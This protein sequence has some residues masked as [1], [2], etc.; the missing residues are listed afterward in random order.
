MTTEIGPLHVRR[1]IWIDAKPERVWEEFEDL[2]HMRA[3]FGT[4]HSLTTYE[5]RVG[6]TVE[7]DA[8]VQHDD[9]DEPLV[10]RGNVLVFDPPRELSFEQDWLG[11]G[12]AVPAIITIRLTEHDTGTLVELFHHGFERM[13]DTATAAENQ[14]GFEDGWTSRQLEALRARVEN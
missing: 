4:G 14:R 5:P 8:N 2:E 7:V 6:G 9:I 13:S 3:W 10:F 12:W 1:S 11:H